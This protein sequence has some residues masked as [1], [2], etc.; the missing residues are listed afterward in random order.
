LAPPSIDW[1]TS[2]QINDGNSTLPSSPAVAVRGNFAYA[3]WEDER[4][5]EHNLF[6]A[7]SSD[8]GQTWQTTNIQV[9]D[10]SSSAEASKPAI[11][12][13]AQGQV[14]IAFHY[15]GD[16]AGIYIVDSS[17]EGET[18]SSKRFVAGVNPSNIEIAIDGNDDLYLAWSPGNGHNPQV[19]R[20]QDGGQTWD[21]AVEVITLVTEGCFPDWDMTA[22]GNGEVYFA[23]IDDC[24]E[25]LFLKSVDGG[26]TWSDEIEIAEEDA[27]SEIG[28]AVDDDN[29]YVKH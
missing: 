5:G 13:D 3:V 14:Y 28:I 22:S 11:A 17:D 29:V 21:E 8:A 19:A 2:T 4:S 1:F 27:D 24:D 15:L 9:T 23:A 7:K 26:Q 6:L 12:V 10:F 18:W 16:D 20:S 25:V